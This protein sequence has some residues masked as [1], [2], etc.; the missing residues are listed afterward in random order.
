MD[1]V[2][3]PLGATALAKIVKNKPSVSNLNT[4]NNFESKKLQLANYFTSNLHC[5]PKDTHKK[6][7]FFN[8]R[9][10]LLDSVRIGQ[11]NHKNST[12]ELSQDFLSSNPF[13][14]RRTANALND[15]CLKSALTYGSN[16]LKQSKN[17]SVSM[18]KRVGHELINRSQDHGKKAAFKGN[19]KTQIE[20][21]DAKQS[22]K[23]KHSPINIFNIKN[24]TVLADNNNRRHKRSLSNLGDNLALLKQSKLLP[25]DSTQ[26]FNQLNPI[27]KKQRSRTLAENI[28]FNNDYIPSQNEKQIADKKG[29]VDTMLKNEK[30][31]R[32][33]SNSGT[34]FQ[35]FESK[36]LYAK[37]G[38]LIDKLTTQTA[39]QSEVTVQKN[40]KRFHQVNYMSTNI[41]SLLKDISKEKLFKKPTNIS[42]KADKKSP[43]PKT[44]K[45]PSM[46]A[47][48]IREI[49]SMNQEQLFFEELLL[50]LRECGVDVENLFAY[51]YERMKIDTSDFSDGNRTANKLLTESHSC[52]GSEVSVLDNASTVLLR[53]VE[54]CNSRKKLKL[55]MRKVKQE[56]FSSQEE[57]LQC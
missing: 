19:N 2:K 55:D 12:L 38:S 35:T 30:V 37:L 25:Q 10:C 4:S 36:I 20:F 44:D 15:A 24:C 41:D 26:L 52:I 1:T 14:S 33:K 3:Q 9:S 56:A 34:S 7:M 28:V 45:P 21:L 16:C 43:E 5:F 39:G 8:Q 54:L 31:R 22:I 6:P 48:L 23:S 50:I 47:Q 29:S 53:K 42:S 49:I 17:G 11:G 32:Q 40:P 57:N 13:V 51:C 27:P 18:L 46:K